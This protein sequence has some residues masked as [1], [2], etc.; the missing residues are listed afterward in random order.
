L[1][2]NQNHVGVIFFLAR[3]RV[4][5]PTTT[6]AMLLVCSLASAKPL[7]PDDDPHGQRALSA[8]HSV[9]AEDWWNDLGNDIEEGFDDLGQ[10]IGKA[11][12]GLESWVEHQKCTLCED[13]AKLLG[14]IGTAILDS[15][16][17]G[18]A[19]AGMIAAIKLTTESQVKG[20]V[21]GDLRAA[22]CGSITGGIASIIVDIDP[23]YNEA[24]LH[25]CLAQ[26]C[27]AFWSTILS[28]LGQSLLSQFLS[29]A[30]AEACGCP[31][32]DF[33][34]C[35]HIHSPP[36]PC[37]IKDSVMVSAKSRATVL[38]EK[39]AEAA[40]HTL[41]NTTAQHGNKAKAVLLNYSTKPDNTYL[42][43]FS[44][45]CQINEFKLKTLHV[46]RN[47]TTREM[48][49]GQMETFVST[50]KVTLQYG[51]HECIS[52]MDCQGSRTCL[53][54]EG[55]L[56]VTMTN[57][58]VTQK[59]LGTCSGNAAECCG[60]DSL[61]SFQASLR[62]SYSSMCPQKFQIEAI[63]YPQRNAIFMPD[64]HGSNVDME[65]LSK[66][67]HQSPSEWIQTFDENC[68]ACS[69]RDYGC[70]TGPSSTGEDD[71]QCRDAR[72]ICKADP[73]TAV[74]PDVGPLWNPF[75]FSAYEAADGAES[76]APPLVNKSWVAIINASNNPA[77]FPPKLCE[78]LPVNEQ[79]CFCK[80][81]DDYPFAQDC[82]CAFRSDDY[83]GCVS[84]GS[85]EWKGIR[86]YG[87]LAKPNTQGW[88]ST[89]SD[90]N[91][92]VYQGNGIQ[93]LDDP[94]Y[95]N[96]AGIQSENDC[97][98]KTMS[99]GSGDFDINVCEWNAIGSCA[100]TVDSAVTARASHEDLDSHTSYS[101][102]SN[103]HPLCW[104]PK[105]QMFTQAITYHSEFTGKFPMTGSFIYQCVS[106]VAKGY[107]CPV[108]RPVPIPAYDE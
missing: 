108:C 11:A 81:K 37:E 50:D 29:V 51:A 107:L 83:S 99:F 17:I 66:Q 73:Y 90:N 46:V 65:E 49:C 70:V 33:D 44:K 15:E 86:P 16:G 61:D 14:Y 92:N 3:K 79:R 27:G 106:D 34:E 72:S 25:G 20:D 54:P 103:D 67:F 28:S 45:A 101:D 104:C 5:M 84:Q 75:A 96:C 76:W 4:A 43:S 31:K 6:A 21:K 18:E 32:P 48:Q 9:Q 59:N 12:Q 55:G 74:D 69:Y 36:Q 98:E 97:N 87:C 26:I 91:G 22:A 68:S 2:C 42:T 41:I 93:E 60:Y 80:S 53:V 102:L 7:L 24:S 1:R 63:P 39:N 94:T 8:G 77:Y 47:G 62:E 13:G 64:L 57:G 95:A 52:D 105:K 85:C 78:Q 82:A 88:Y 23:G 71:Q 40:M 100:Y 30:A 89:G 19:E 10:A 38:A 58:R 56:A 35:L